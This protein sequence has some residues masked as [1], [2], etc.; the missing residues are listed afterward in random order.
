[1]D[2]FVA[3]FVAIAVIGVTAVL[4]GGWMIVAVMRGL[5]QGINLLLGPIGGP[6]RLPAR[7]VSNANVVRCPRARCH[8]ENPAGVQFCRRCGRSLLAEEPRAHRPAAML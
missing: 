1:M 6:P 3:I 8:A 4:F 2:A 7:P 5:A